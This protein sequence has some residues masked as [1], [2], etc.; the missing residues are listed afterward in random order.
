MMTDVGAFSDADLA[1]S[2]SSA[3][4]GEA[5]AAEGEL[6]SRLA[7]RLRLYGASASARRTGGGGSRAAGACC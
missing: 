2:I 4:P 7:S 1:R 6:Y 3:A 5:S